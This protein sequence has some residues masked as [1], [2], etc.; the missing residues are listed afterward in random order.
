VVDFDNLHATWA[1]IA[2]HSYQH[3]IWALLSMATTGLSN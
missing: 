1:L 3:Q 2:E